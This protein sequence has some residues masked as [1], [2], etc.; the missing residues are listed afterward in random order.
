MRRG[1][2]RV[3]APGC[4]LVLFAAG[5]AGEPRGP[6]ISGWS[7]ERVEGV[8]SDAALDAAR[9]ALSQWFRVERVDRELLTLTSA[10]AETTERGAT[11]RIRDEAVGYRNR[12]RRLATLR[13]RATADGGVI[14]ECHVRR[15]RLDTS[16][17]A[18]LAR[19]MTLD[20]QPT[21]TPVESAAGVSAEQ[22]QVWTDIGRD[23]E[24]ERRILDVLRSRVQRRGAAPANEASA[25]QPT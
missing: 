13:L 16:D 5:C 14:A 8:T 9:Y 17:H 2:G 7:R 12:I 20:D 24:L 6:R 3:W 21:E 18:A 22:A 19:N 11:G 1:S 4:L 10:A 25:T 15:E 23:R